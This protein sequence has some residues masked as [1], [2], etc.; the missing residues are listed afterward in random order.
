MGLKEKKADDAVFWADS[1]A[2][3]IITRTK[4]RYI[5]REVE[6]KEP[7]IVKTSASI[8]GVLHIGR[9]SDT[10]RG[11]AVVRALRDAGY[12]A[13]LIW[14]A[15]DMDP[16]RKIP[17]GVPKEYEEYIGMPVSDVPDPWGCHDS[18]ADH[19]KDE[20]FRVLEEFVGVE[21]PKYSMR[22]E[23]KK[24][25][26]NPYIKKFL[27]SIEL[28]KEIM[29]KY[30]TT[31][32]PAG[33]SP[34][35]PICE[36]CGKIITPRV[37]GIEDGK[38][39]YICQDYQFEKHV[40]KG[41]GY[42]GYAD[43]LSGNG[44]LMW[45]SEWAAQWARWRVVAEGAGKE[46]Q[47][48]TSAFWVNAELV[49]RVLGHPSPVPIFYEHIMIDGQ[50]MSASLG[51]VIYPRDWLEVA[52]P[53]VLRYLYCKKLMKMRSFSWKMLP[54]LYDEF[55]TVARIYHGME[56]ADNEKEEKHLKRLYE[57]SMVR[58][59]LPVVPVSYAH[60]A[61]VAQIFT[62]DE[63]IVNALKRTG[64][65]DEEKH[66]LIMKRVKQAGTWARKYAPQEYRIEVKEMVN[67]GIK[68]ILEDRELEAM[69]ELAEKLENVAEKK[70]DITDSDL[71]ELFTEVI[72]N[73]NLTPQKFF[74]AF[75]LCLLGKERGPRATTLIL[76]IT[77]AKVA[78]V[79]RTIE[80]LA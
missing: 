76:S 29:N 5:D 3:E 4:F 1:I 77:P 15:E 32:L 54:N 79:L 56:K 41:C 13:R 23:Y 73:H 67:E 27:E 61:M 36:N 44:K 10:I 57:M 2:R 63:D 17:A 48:P 69:L 22:E 34:W 33:W 18:Y 16:L 58:N 62:T 68:H 80:N 24:G 35:V 38:V 26:F 47:V 45:K 30:R 6:L 53:E 70:G 43:P 66:D 50:K 12:D 28:A 49:E 75:Y 51:N 55:D 11:E 52:R 64:H 7:L 19:H 40:A 14:V 21:M 42:E 20:Y 37:I 59:I 74:R 72:K 71:K 31:P 25:S 46:Y 9:L 65:Y 60:A 78:K 39:H 8:S